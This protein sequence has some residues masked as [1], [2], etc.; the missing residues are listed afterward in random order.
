MFF[1]FGA[2]GGELLRDLSRAIEDRDRKPLRF[3]VQDEILAHDR[4]ADQ[5]NITL[6][7][8]HFEYLVEASQPQSASISTAWQ[9]PI[10]QFC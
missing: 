7:R 2:S 5:A 9:F 10:C 6:I 8:I 3:H 1:P 4:E